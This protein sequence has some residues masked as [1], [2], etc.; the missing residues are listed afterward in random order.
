MRSRADFLA[1]RAIADIKMDCFV[2]FPLLDSVKIVH[3]S[4]QIF[5]QLYPKVVSAISPIDI[6]SHV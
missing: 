6:L 2:Q 3:Y 4:L 5:H 1:L